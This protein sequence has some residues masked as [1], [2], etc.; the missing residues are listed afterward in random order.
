MA[1]RWSLPDRLSFSASASL[2]FP[3][4]APAP[5][6]SI[7]P[8]MPPAWSRPKDRAREDENPPEYGNCIPPLPPPP[9]P[10][11]NRL[12]KLMPP[13]LLPRW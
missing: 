9:A 1:S 3:P 5:P 10:P 7:R 13:H 6:G 12:P 11:S 4:S 2:A 8:P